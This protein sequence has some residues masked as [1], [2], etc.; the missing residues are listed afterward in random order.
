MEIILG[1]ATILGGIAAFVYFLEKATRAK[2]AKT[3]A[4][5]RSAAALEAR[6]S[7]EPAD[8]DLAERTYFRYRALSCPLLA[9][10]EVVTHLEQRYRCEALTINSTRLPVTVLWRNVGELI[11]P[12]VI[13]GDLDPTPPRPFQSSPVLNEL[14]YPKARDFIKRQYEAPPSK[15]TYEGC[16][17]RMTSIDLLRAVPRLSGAFGL[18]Y[19]NILTQ[20][21]LEWELKK[22]LLHEGADPIANLSEPASLPLR[23]AVENGRNPLIDGVGRCAAITISTLVVFRRSSGDLYTILERRS[24][25]VG[26]SPGLHHVVPAGMFEAPNTDDTWSVEDNVWRELLEEVYDEEEQLGQGWAEIKD[27]V[28]SQVPINL[29]CDL[30]NAGDAELSV[31]GICCDLLNL[32]PEIC[33]VLYLPSAAFAEARR[34]ILN[35]EYERQGPQGRFGVKWSRAGEVATELA[36]TSS[37]VVSGAACISLG[38]EW[39]SARH[40]V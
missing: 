19:D 35:W 13:L 26:V 17:Y 7:E 11:H 29:L 23:E 14:E 2:R 38:R 39:L 32:R 33:T 20:Y 18:Y 40:G 25:S 31:T 27:Y 21:A 8:L 30:I 1:I 16:D 12:D 15:I 3:L 37:I 22:A 4:A 10:R 28:R 34:M 36:A 6:P 9:S 24:K 5:R